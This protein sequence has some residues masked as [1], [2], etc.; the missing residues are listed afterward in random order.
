MF[1]RG[2]FPS[3]HFSPS[4]FPSGALGDVAA[5]EPERLDVTFG[6]YVSRAVRQFGSS[7]SVG[8]RRS[9][10]SVASQRPSSGSVE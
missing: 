4:Y 7:V 9:G 10:S 3:A 8:V 6:S 1:A 2:F 5:P